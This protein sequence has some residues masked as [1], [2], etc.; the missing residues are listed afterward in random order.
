VRTR[1]RA[2]DELIALCIRQTGVREDTLRRQA[3]LDVAVDLAGR[4]ERRGGGSAMRGTR[5]RPR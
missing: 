5:P 3:A 4:V 2:P 1:A